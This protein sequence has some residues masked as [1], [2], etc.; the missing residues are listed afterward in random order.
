MAKCREPIKGHVHYIHPCFVL[1]L[2]STNQVTHG[3]GLQISLFLKP[4]STLLST[5]LELQHRS[6]INWPIPSLH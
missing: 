5:L 6:E 1:S 2:A 4:L 3:C